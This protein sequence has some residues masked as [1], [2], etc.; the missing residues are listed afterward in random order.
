[1]TFKV[2]ATDYDGTLAANGVVAPTAAAALDRWRSCGRK[3]VLVTGRTL[4]DLA[5][6]FPDFGAFDRIVAENGATL[7]RATDGERAL[8]A[9]PP[10]RFLDR[11]RA[12]GVPFEVGRVVVATRVPHDVTVLAAI[13]ELGLDLQVVFNKGA[14]MVLPAGVDKASGL[15]AA[16]NELGLTPRDAVGVGDA[17]NDTAFLRACG[18]A[19]AVANALPEVKG[20][21]HVVTVGARGAGV[22]EIIHRVLADDVA[23]S[24]CLPER[25]SLGEY[26][27]LF[28]SCRAVEPH[29][30]RGSYR[31]VVVGPA[32]FQRLFRALL[33][34]GG[35][36]GWEGK[37]FEDRAGV[38]LCRRRGELRRIAPMH[39]A[40]L[41]AS[42]VDGRPAL[43][44]RYRESAPLRLVR[45]ELRS[46]SDGVLLGM[47]YADVEPL[48]RVQMPFA[49]VRG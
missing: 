39:V 26:R 13:R 11:L 47:T 7:W 6:V 30:L 46:L 16:L 8:A 49:L 9:P 23:P 17:E 18:C 5:H 15:A 20:V 3:L 37:V 10:A 28:R 41:S 43:V 12:A 25:A 42:A 34:L 38:N 29:E 19:V 24:A 44:V 32:W 2:L 21:T 1:V 22:E 35:L 40:G 4:P 36:A 45:D 31:G 33:V 27:Q 48:R 14:V